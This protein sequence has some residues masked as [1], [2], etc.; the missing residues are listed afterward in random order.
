MAKDR[1]AARRQAQLCEYTQASSTPLLLSVHQTNHV[2][3]MAK[4]NEGVYFAY[5]RS[6]QKG[7][8]I[9]LQQ[10]SEEL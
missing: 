3:A 10:D 9:I 2:K 1:T 4:G 8:C 6:W 7:A 5:F